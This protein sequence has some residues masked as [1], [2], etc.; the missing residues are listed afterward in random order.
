[1]LMHEYEVM[2]NYHSTFGLVV[3]KPTEK[4]NFSIKKVTSDILVISVWV[5]DKVVPTST[6]TVSLCLS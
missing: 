4:S 3:K 1:M 5:A 6:K 2:F